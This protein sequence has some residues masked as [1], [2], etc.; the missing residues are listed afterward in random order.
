[1]H[2]IIFIADALASVGSCAMNIIKYISGPCKCFACIVPDHYSQSE[3]AGLQT[4]C[5]FEICMAAM[6]IGNA[7]KNLVST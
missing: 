4:T 5:E 6:C 7:P 2:L 1:M 3:W